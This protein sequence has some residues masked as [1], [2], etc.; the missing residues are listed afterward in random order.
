KIFL[1][2]MVVNLIYSIVL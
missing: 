2:H 1:R